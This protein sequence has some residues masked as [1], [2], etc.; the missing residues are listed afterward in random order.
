MREKTVDVND[1]YMLTN[2]DAD[3]LKAEDAKDYL[4]K[5][6][7]D[8]SLT[9]KNVM[10]DNTYYKYLSN[11]YGMLINSKKSIVERQEIYD[12]VLAGKMIGGAV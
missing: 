3:T 7:G 1:I 2:T 9:Y 4:K 11:V 10:G 12:A 5:K 8:A 6:I